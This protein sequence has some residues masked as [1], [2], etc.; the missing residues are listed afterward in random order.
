MISSKYNKFLLPIEENGETRFYMPIGIRVA[1]FRE[2]YPQGR[3][4]T[5]ILAAD[6]RYAR[7]K[8]SIYFYIKDKTPVSCGHAEMKISEYDSFDRVL[9][10]AETKAIG[11]ALAY[12]GF[13][14]PLDAELPE[15]TPCDTGV[16]AT[17]D[18]S[19][20]VDVPK[21]TDTFVQVF[22]ATITKAQFEE[23]M[24]N[25]ELLDKNPDL[26][27]EFKKKFREK[28]CSRKSAD[29]EAKQE[30]TP[31]QKPKAT[32]TR[33]R[34]Q[35]ARSFVIEDGKFKGSTLGEAFIREPACVEYY[36]NQPTTQIGEAARIILAYEKRKK[37]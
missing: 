2:Q 28:Y 17:G 29:D 21:S 11:R 1:A 35:W 20:S 33:E 4:E 32:I 16:R 26:S 13:G 19:N 14:T 23:F 15:K 34:L 22:N 10:S 6:E 24:K 18:N 37:R 3:I 12:A 25:P 5:E 27:G 9:E 7:V 8:A 30:K 36:A 31:D